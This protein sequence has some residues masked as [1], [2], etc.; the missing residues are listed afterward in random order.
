MKKYLATAIFLAFL[1]A[2]CL[3]QDLQIPQS[4]LLR[5][6]ERKSGLIAYIGTDGNV[7]VSDQGGGNLSKLTDDA[8]ITDSQSG[9][10]KYYQ[11][12]TW[13]L[14][15]KKLAF[16]GLRVEGSQVTSEL[17]V[18]DVENGKPTSVYSSLTEHPFYLY[19]SPD[20]SNLSYLST[21]AGGQSIM[22]QTV[23]AT[24]GER[25]ILDTG[26]QYYWSWA[27]DGQIMIVHASRSTDATDKHL[28]FL[29]LDREVT[30][31]GLDT[32]PASFQAPAWSPD[33]SHILLADV[34]E[35]GE[36]QIVL[37]DATGS[38]EKTI[39]TFEINTAFAWSSDSEKFAYISGKQE[40]SAGT[41]GD[42]HIFDLV[43][44]EEIGQDENVVA[45]FWSPNGEKLAY[46]I[47]FLNNT[48]TGS[49]SES[50]T[51][52]QQQLVLQMNVFDVK[53][54]EKSELFTFAP[55]SLFTEILPYFDQ[56]HQS[57]TIW[58]PDNNNLV[59]SLLN[60]DGKPGIAVVAA[61]GNLEPRLLAE[62]LLA[63]WSWK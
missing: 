22:L 14:D 31:F 30:E 6:L 38:S 28:A 27:P 32:I 59:I 17:D 52:P 33:G 21:T 35:Q 16:V 3:P 39:G 53:T 49:G 26:I 50:G 20:N 44:S 36:N 25:K 13:S 63:F 61:S 10:N 41:L 12:P 37:T 56:Y 19:W 45:F 34:N 4:P 24:G 43:T 5:T 18:T 54:G 51:N 23:P 60:G 15:G 7:Y 62:G 8:A 46:F 1:L 58:S 2:S 47:P 9:E 57:V 48:S 40:L 29:R 42:L 11:Y 55:T